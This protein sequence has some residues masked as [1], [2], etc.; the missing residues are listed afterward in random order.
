M[1]EIIF[2]TMPQLAQTIR[3]GRTQRGWTI[4]EL[5]QK[6]DVPQV[7][8]RNSEHGKVIPILSL[9]H[10]LKALDILDLQLP[11]EYA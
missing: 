1:S 6:A 11:V 3:D 10:I 9:Q 5:A 4:R 7:A 2:D 8:I